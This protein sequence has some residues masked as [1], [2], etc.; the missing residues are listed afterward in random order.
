MTTRPWQIW[1][2]TG[3]TFTDCLAVDPSGVTRSAKVLSSSALRGRIESVTGARSARLRLGWELPDHFLEG[4]T[5]RILDGSGRQAT[6]ERFTA[7]HCEIEVDADFPRGLDAG[8]TCELSAAVEAPVL[9]S[10]LVTGTPLPHALPPVSM[11]LATT[12]GTNALLERR[13]AP[14]VL[15][16]TRGFADLLTIGTQQRPELF[17][18]NVLKPEPLYDAV[19]EVPE[20]LDADG[21]VI[22]PLDCDALPRTVHELLEQGLRCAAVALMHSYHEP[23]HERELGDF[24]RAA[25]FD[26]V[27]CSSELAPLIKLLP[28][29]QT[30]V[31]DAYLGPIIQDY[32]RGVSSAV[33]RGRLHV[34]TSAGGVV[35]AAN[36]HATDALLSGPAG[37]V[38]GAS[39]AGRR[40]GTERVIA[41]DMGGTSTDVA[42]WDGDFEYVFSHRVGDATLMAPA[43]AIESVAAGGGSICHF[44]G[45]QIGVGPHSAGA[46]PGPACYGAGGPLS[47]T[48]VNLLLGRIEPDLFEIP[49][50]STAAAEAAERVRQDMEAATGDATTLDTLL[51]GFLQIANERMAAAIRR[52]SVR[53]GYDPSAYTLVAFGGAGPQHAC[54]VA[55]LLGVERALVPPNASLLSAVGLGHALVERFAHR[56]VLAHLDDMGSRLPQLVED[57]DREAR[58]QVE[59]EGLASDEVVIRRRIANLRLAGQESTLPVEWSAGLDI[60]AAF[61]DRYRD[62]YGYEPPQRP[63]EV[64]S[65]RVV[66]STRP[67]EVAAADPAPAVPATTRNSRSVRLGGAWHEVPVYRRQE[68]D[69]GATLSGPAL[70]V[71]R[72][73]VTV[74]EPGWTL[75][76]DGSGALV[77]TLGSDEARS[78][79]AI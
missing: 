40:S 29:A 33:N 36:F 76:V 5:L 44:D 11:R 47:I 66:A 35:S 52:I 67:E 49:I 45:A 51:E 41:F 39:R 56:Q 69:S 23:Q 38:V 79:H 73:S 65:L 28:R 6:V 61:A 9:A 20:R 19:V 34:M 12:R 7:N 46:D 8:M 58:E 1:V 27:A 54:A 77:L 50:S 2:D 43:L 59:S 30:A 21:N 3:G 70:V 42:R 15:F 74:V 26:H 48:D 18:L 75:A 17:A 14:T 71:E 57:L 16:I 64:E 13:G 68:L 10:H 37:G 24:L 55:A 72:H 32:L 62:V 31:V 22:T 53:Q 60:S 25:G 78:D 4:T 63:I